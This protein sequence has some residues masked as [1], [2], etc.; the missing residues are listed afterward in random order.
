MRRAL[1]SDPVGQIIYVPIDCQYIPNIGGRGEKGLNYNSNNDSNNNSAIFW[2]K[3]K[4]YKAKRESGWKHKNLPE[5]ASDGR[6]EETGSICWRDF[7]DNLKK[8]LS[9]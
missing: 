4:R 1:R 5:L 9:E 2:I 6:T 7:D 8:W 3:K